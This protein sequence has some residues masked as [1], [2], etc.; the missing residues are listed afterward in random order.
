MGGAKRGGGEGGANRVHQ[1][2]TAFDFKGAVAGLFEHGF[3][4]ELQKK[5]EKRKKSNGFCRSRCWALRVCEQDSPMVSKL[6]LVAILNRERPR[7]V[8]KSQLHSVAML[9]SRT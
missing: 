7:I 1:T 2:R 9:H 4:L 3:N 8:V 6:Q 5:K